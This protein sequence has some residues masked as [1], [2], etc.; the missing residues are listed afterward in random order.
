[1]EQLS[2][3]L[4]MRIE[5]IR[6]ELEFLEELHKELHAPDC[7]CLKRLKETLMQIGPK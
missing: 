1:M 4:D 6:D 5:A 3:I 2:Q 7:R